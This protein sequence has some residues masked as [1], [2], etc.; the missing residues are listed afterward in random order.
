M[1]IHRNGLGFFPWNLKSLPKEQQNTL[2]WISLTY[3]LRSRYGNLVVKELQKFEVA[4]SLRK[5]KL[6]LT[7]LISNSMFTK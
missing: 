1:G 6:D 3:V 7:F 4:Y 5:Y 2:L